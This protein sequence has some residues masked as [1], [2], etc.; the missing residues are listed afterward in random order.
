MKKLLLIGLLL[1]LAGCGS[2]NNNNTPTKTLEDLLNEIN[3]P[4][5]VNEDLTLPDKYDLNGEE[6]LAIWNSSD[7]NII[8]SEGVIKQGFENQTVTLTL[9]LTSTNDYKTKEFTIT[10]LALDIESFLESAIDILNIPL[11]TSSNLTLPKYV[12]YEGK[13][14]NLTYT[15]NNQSAL[16]NDG[17]VG[18]IPNNTDIELTVT[19]TI[20]EGTY[21]KKIPITIIALSK[22]E[23]VEYVFNHIEIATNIANNINLP[24]TFAF[25]MTGTWESNNHDV[26]LDNGTIA[27]GF[28]G[29]AEIKLTLTLNTGD[30]REFTVIVSKNNHLI[31]DRTFLGE[32]EN[33][34]IKNGLLVLTNEATSGTYESEV[35]ETLGFTEAVASWA[36]TSSTTAT[37]ELFIRVR[38]DNNWSKYFSYGEWGLGLQNRA[39]NQEDNIAKLTTDEIIVKN[40]K[41]ASAL[42]FKI[43][44]KR[45]NTTTETPKVTLLASALNIPNYSYPVNIDNISRT[46]DYDVPKLNQNVVPEIGDIICSATSSTMLLKFKGHN[47]SSYD[48][49]EHRYIA[50]LVKDYEHNIYG[51]WVYNTVGMSAFGEVSYVKRMYS[52]QELL[53]HLDTVGPIAASVKGTMIGEIGRTWTTSG[54]LIVVRGYR[55][56]N[57]EIYILANDPNM[58][59]VYEEYKLNNFLNVWRNIAYVIE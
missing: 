27:Q 20:T 39:V 18:L 47:F 43:I 51:N 22:A 50:G 52:Y 59:N 28:S 54:H 32:K 7:E 13:R 41:K 44:L 40:N 56:E 25:N 55:I 45:T 3:L 5:E 15:S 19:A 1:I 46:R 23:Q 14:V 57:N 8:S 16:T 24:T 29:R 31:L 48:N 30:R 10:V 42:Q 17:K 2:K 49:Y 35:Y 37:C 6:V 58:P 53:Y 34:E 26:L 38:V 21:N 9:T 4:E 33:L 36:A 11:S 12:T